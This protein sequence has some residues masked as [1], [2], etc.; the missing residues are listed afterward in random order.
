ML[1]GHIVEYPSTDTLSEAT[2]GG[3]EMDAVTY[4]AC[5]DLVDTW[6]VVSEEDIRWGMKYIWDS[7]QERVEGAAGMCVAAVRNII[8]DNNN[9]DLN[10][11]NVCVLLCGGNIDV[12]TH[13]KAVC[14]QVQ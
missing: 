10:N 6:Q 8:T 14:V 13:Y 4:P 11:K 5:R 12:E 3:V 9:I 7:H 2:A 1:A